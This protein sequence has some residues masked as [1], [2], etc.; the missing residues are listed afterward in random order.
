[1]KKDKRLKNSILEYT[2]RQIDIIKAAT[3]LIG[4]L[5]VS[6]LTTKNLAAEMNFS[7]PALYRHFKNKN[8]ILKSVLLYYKG[9]MKKFIAPLLIED[10][11]GM[12]RIRRLFKFQFSHFKSN[13]AIVLVIFSET[14]FQNNVMLSKTVLEIMEQKKNM[15]TSI[16][17]LG[18]K[19]GSIRSDV[20]SDQ[21]TTIIMG[22]MRLSILQWRLTDFTQN[23][24]EIREKL[25]V[26]FERI[27]K[28]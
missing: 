19:D 13:P 28:E 12:E 26:A 9:D 14:S 1:M 21:L 4:N 8:E 22:S 17:D 11:S 18:Q 10:S 25:W 20:S 3:T 15:M 27:L 5:G 6:G 24:D 7:E 16:I 23:L 2:N